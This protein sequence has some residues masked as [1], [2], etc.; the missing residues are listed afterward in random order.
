MAVDS[1]QNGVRSGYSL[2]VCVYIYV[3]SYLLV[4]FA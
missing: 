1:R 3:Y 4:D 2:Q